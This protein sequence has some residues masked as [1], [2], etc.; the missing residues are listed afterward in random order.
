MTTIDLLV[1]PEIQELIDAH[2]L[3]TLGDVAQEW[4]PPDLA[5]LVIR[6]DHESQ[7]V[8]FQSL[9]M[10][11][12][13]DVFSYLPF[14][15]QEALVENLPIGEISKILDG[16]PP[17]DRTRF[18]AQLPS[19]G[20]LRLLSLL[21]PEERKVAESLLAYPQ[22]S[23]GRLMTPDYIAVKE[24]WT[25]QHVLD[26]IRTYGKDSET[27]NAIYVTDGHGKLIDDIR[28]RQVLLASPTATVHELMDHNFVWLRATHSKREAVGLF[29]KYD[30]TALPVVADNGTLLG[31]VTIDDVLDIAEQEA[32]REIQQLGGSEALDEPYLST[33]LHVMIKKRAVWLVVLFLG[34]LLT[35]TAIGFF[36]GEIERAVVLAMFIPLIISSGGNSGSQAATLMVRAL[37]LGELRLSQWP[38]VLRR[39]IVS[40]LMLGIT[41]GLIG[42]SRIALWSAFTNLY[43][44]HWLLVA[45]TVGISLVGVVLW[46]S[47]AG[48]MLPIILRRV[49]LDPA[50]SSAP[51]VATMVDV[52]GLIIYFTVALVVLHGTLL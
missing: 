32:T 30:R 29:R 47:L 19:D 15:H 4:L 44:E 10:S 14:H 40:G 20:K 37:A 1:L 16:M 46:G 43:G 42:F 48:A 7:A 5:A 45:A 24:N 27:L 22:G 50:T 17:D 52:T 28:M 11:R 8:F 34:E 12:A 33:P 25:V 23:I 21:A 26:F 31:I 51:F 35:A 3:A 6:L 38:R 2:D 41:L 39:E 36:E 13:A 49:G 9:E 18:L